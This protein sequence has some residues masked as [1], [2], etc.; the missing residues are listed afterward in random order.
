VTDLPML[1]AVGHPVAV[2]ADRPL[3]RISRMRGWEVVRFD[4][5][6]RAMARRSVRWRQRRILQ[7]SVLT[8]M[9]TSGLGAWFWHRRLLLSVS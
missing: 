2:N 8:L 6:T 7:L 9:A 4:L 5:P 3:E 1:E